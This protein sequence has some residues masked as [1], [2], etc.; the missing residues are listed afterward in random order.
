MSQQIVANRPSAQ[1]GAYVTLYLAQGTLFPVTSART[2]VDAL[3]AL[4]SR[5]T[6]IDDESYALL[7]ELGMVLQVDV[8]ELMNKSPNRREALNAYVDSLQQIM[9]LSMTEETKLKTVVLESQQ[10]E[11]KLVREDVQ[12]IETQIRNAIREKN[13]GQAAA[14]QPHLT[15]AETELAGLRSKKEQTQSLL[16]AFDDLLRIGERRYQAM[17]EN[18]E[19]IL[20]G[21]K[22]LEIPGVEDLSILEQARGTRS[23]REGGGFFESVLLGQ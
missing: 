4:L 10:E 5:Q 17:Q 22:V 15:D 20:A 3:T 23:R 18:R 11:E 6:T 19:V 8:T 7:Q 16:N 9:E 2:G 13:Y 14:L 12:D 1:L 21:L